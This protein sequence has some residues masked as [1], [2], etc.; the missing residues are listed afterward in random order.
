M[1]TLQDT[2]RARLAVLEPEHVG[3]EDDS[4]AHRGHAGA[5]GGGGHFTLTLVSPRFAGLNRIARHHLVYQAL[6]D[7]IPV[8]IHA[9]ALTT[10]APDE[11]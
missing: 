1:T 9:L 8:R 10:L 11:L 6:G 5:A 7:L 2:I 3:L 4:A